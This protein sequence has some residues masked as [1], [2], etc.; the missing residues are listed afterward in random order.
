L[1][2]SLWHSLRR[3]TTEG[4]MQAEQVCK[5]HSNRLWFLN[6]FGMVVVFILQTQTL[7]YI[8]NLVSTIYSNGHIRLTFQSKMAS[9]HYHKEVLDS[10]ILK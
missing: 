5:I 7:S 1:L 10:V 9:A 4:L 3:T 6:F 8:R 2:P